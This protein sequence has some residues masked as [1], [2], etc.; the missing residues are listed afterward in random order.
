MPPDDE[1]IGTIVFDLDG[2]V[3]VG[4][5]EIP[6]AGRTLAALDD[7]GWRLLFATNNSSR[8]ADDV[9]TKIADV[10]GYR[11]TTADVVT[12]GLA[13][14]HHVKEGSKVF[15]VGEPGLVSTF[16]GHGHVTTTDP[17]DADTVIVGVDFSITYRDIS[18]AARAIRNG[19]EFVA[20]NTDATFPTPSGLLPG[21]GA[22]VAAIAT[23]SGCE[24]IVCGK[25]H[26]P[27]GELILERIEGESVWM[28]GDRPETDIAF[29][30]KFG[31]QTVLVSTGVTN[32]T[33]AIPDAYLPD[34]MVESIVDLAM[35]VSDG[36]RTAQTK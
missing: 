9:A 10:A 6:G 3:Y 22:G 32:T 36:R 34:H 11:P 8:T 26:R 4:S 14:A 28:V 30:K 19:A 5:Q 17:D 21:A 7:L 29:G 24:P 25:P 2:V 18:D 1:A 33:S 31:W 27:M 15:V 23:A 13:A 12:S 20:T 35:L 16:E